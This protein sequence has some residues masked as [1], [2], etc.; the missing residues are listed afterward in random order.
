[1]NGPGFWSWREDMLTLRCQVQPRAARGEIVGEHGGRLRVRV[2]AVPSDGAANQRLRE[3][4]AREFGVATGAVE[5]SAG[6]GN[7]LKTAIIQQP[8]RVPPG[9]GIERDQA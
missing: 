3:I 9:L 7:R 2:N 4:L 1:M 5:I 6:H 8:K